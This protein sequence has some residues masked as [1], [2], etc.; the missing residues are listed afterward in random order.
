MRPI[1]L[2]VVVSCLCAQPALQVVKPV[3]SQSDGGPPDT[4][5]TQHAAGEVVFFSCRIANYSKT[6]EQKIHLAYSVQPFDPQGVPLEEI[7]KNEITDE[8]SPQDK[9][10]MPKIATEL[11]IPPLALSGT[12]KIVVKIEDL[13]SQTKAELEVPLPVRGRD[14]PPSDTVVIRNFRFFRNENDVQP[15][16]KAAYKPGD[17]VWA[18]FDITG[19]KYGPGN[20]VDV[21]YVTSVL[22]SSGKVLWTQPEPAVEQSESF[23][24]KRY[25]TADFGLNLQKTIKPGEYTILVQVKDAVG[26]QSYEAKQVFTVE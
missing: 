22:S 24:P 4:G 19:Y 21:S 12:Y 5:G 7:Y 16:D 25:F 1:L 15:A 10:W 6:P 11:P 20:K 3:I 14:V 9:E 8:V 17:G 13:V 18:K 23:Y 2:L 26:G